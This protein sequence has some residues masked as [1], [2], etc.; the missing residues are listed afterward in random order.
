MRGIH[1]TERSTT[2]LQSQGEEPTVRGAYVSIKSK[3][4]STNTKYN[5]INNNMLQMITST[6][7]VTTQHTHTHTQT[8]AAGSQ[9]GDLNQCR[10]DGQLQAKY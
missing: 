7:L 6:Y 2:V 8:H 10:L 1:N 4:T 5:K 9:Q 3:L